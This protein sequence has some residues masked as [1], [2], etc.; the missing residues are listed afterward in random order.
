ML[1]EVAGDDWTPVAHEKSL[2]I[3]NGTTWPA[4]Y[5]VANFVR[6]LVNANGEAQ[7]TIQGPTVSRTEVIPWPESR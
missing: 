6:L 3:V 2:A 7:F 5:D 4:S 1:S